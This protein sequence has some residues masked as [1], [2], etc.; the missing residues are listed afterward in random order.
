VTTL[1]EAGYGVGVAGWMVN[2]AKKARASGPS[3]LML[4]EGAGESDGDVAREE[5]H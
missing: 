2:E 5:D 4:F 3:V 1:S